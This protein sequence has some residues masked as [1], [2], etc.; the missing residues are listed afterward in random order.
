MNIFDDAAEEGDVRSRRA[1]A[2]RYRRLA[3]VRVKRGSTWMILAPCSTLAFIG[4][5][6]ATGMVLRHVG[7]HDDD[8]VGVGH[9]PRVEGRRAAAE[10]GPQTGDARAVSYPRLIL[11]GDDA[12][13]AHEL[14]VHV[15]ELDL[16]GGAA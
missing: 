11:D 5:R 10:S 6:K 1:P 13:A 12:E 8:A 4:Q 2:R 3:L 16:E 9:A 14:L 7:A 15:V